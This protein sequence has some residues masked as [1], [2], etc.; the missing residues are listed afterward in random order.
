MNRKNLKMILIILCIIIISG[1]FF[2]NKLL[3]IKTMAL[4]PVSYPV[5]VIDPG[6]GGVDPG[7]IGPSSILEKDI[8]LQ[9]ALKLYTLIEEWGGTAV[10][11]RD[12]DVGLYRDDPNTTLRKKKQEDLINRVEK[13]RLLGGNILL[14]IHM[15]AHLSPKWY[16][17]QVFYH[18]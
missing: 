3:Y 2:I 6:H 17:A 8:N 18:K 1:I 14:S 13:A 5:I 4:L 11:T 9:T 10:L 15:N 12:E 7:A 16:G